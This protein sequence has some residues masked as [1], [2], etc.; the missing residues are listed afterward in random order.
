MGHC[1]GTKESRHDATIALICVKIHSPYECRWLSS[2]LGSSP[3]GA[4]TGG[5]VGIAFLLQQTSSPTMYLLY[6]CRW[7][8]L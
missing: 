2:I 8:T 7:S 6:M 5:V 1:P 4:G 3:N